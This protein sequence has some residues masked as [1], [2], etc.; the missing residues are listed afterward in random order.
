MNNLFLN[1]TKLTSVIFG[2]INTL[3]LRNMGNMFYGCSS[4]KDL[5]L[6]NFDT[7]KV[8]NMRY[9]FYKCISLISLN[10]SM[11]KASSLNDSSYMFAR[12]NNLISLDL[13]NFNTSQTTLMNYMFYNCQLLQYLNISNFNTINVTGMDYMFKYCFSLKYLDLS[14]FY[15]PNLKSN[16]EMFYG[17]YSLSSLDISNFNTTLINDLSNLFYNCSSLLYLNLSSFNTIN[18]KKMEYMFYNF[19]SL[20]SLNLNNFNTEKVE[21]MLGMFYNC[22]KLT[23][24]DLSSFNTKS[25]KSMHYMFDNCKKLKKLNLSHFYTPELKYM[26]YM[27]YMCNSLTSLD[28]TNLNTT[29]T[30]N[31]KYAFSHCKKL[32]QLNVSNFDTS[33]VVNMSFTFRYLS[34]LKSLDLSNFDTSSVKDMQHMFSYCKSLIYLNLSNFKTISV[35]NIRQM[36][37]DCQN[38]QYIDFYLYNESLIVNLNK[39]LDY[40]PENIIV[41]LNENNNID[42]FKSSILKKNYSL[43]YCGDDW[44]DKQIQILE[45]YTYILSNSEEELDEDED[46]GNINGNI[47]EENKDKDNCGQCL[48]EDDNDFDI[49]INTNT[50]SIN[51]SI[52]EMNNTYIDENSDNTNNIDYSITEALFSEMNDDTNKMKSWLLKATNY[53]NTYNNYSDQSMSEKINLSGISLLSQ[54]NDEKFYN[55]NNYTSQE[56]NQMIYQNITN[57]ILNNFDPL[58]DDEIIIE[59]KDNVHY[60]L[61]TL[62][63]AKNNTHEQISRIDIGECEDKLRQTNNINNNTALLILLLEKKSNISSERNLQFEIYESLNKTKLDLTVCKDI[64]IEIYVPLILNDKLINLYNELKELGYDLFNINDKFYQDICTPYTTENNTDA[65]LSDRINYYYNNDQTQCQAGCDFSDYVFEIQKLKCE[66]NITKTQIN[67]EIKIGDDGLKSLYKSFYDVLK[68]S[69]YKVLKCYKLAFSWNNFYK[70]IGTILVLVYFVIYL[71]FLLIYVFKEKDELRIDLVKIMYNSNKKEINNNIP[72]IIHQNPDAIISS[73]PLNDTQNKKIKKSQRNS[74]SEKRKTNNTVLYPPKKG[75]SLRK[76]KIKSY[77]KESVSLNQL[78]KTINDIKEK[79]DI[80]KTPL[81]LNNSEKNEI[82]DNFEL[83]DMEYD[84]ALKSDKRNFIQIYW[85]ILRREHLIIFTFFIRNDHNL[86]NI[87]YVRFIFLLCT[88]MALN[89]FFFSDETMHKMFLDYGKYNFIQ[90]IPQIVYSTIVTQ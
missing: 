39:I 13:Y 38:L 71:T 49:D 26:H 36:F 70:N 30:V 89:V 80:T 4:L 23:S 55:N 42:L 59:G 52:N 56:I 79:K 37:Y 66:C 64:P 35:T 82:F 3:K 17:A 69:N 90:Q 40:T 57:N 58:K 73:S 16:N 10:I 78:L 8:T 51:N 29:K 27:F 63:K 54:I 18:T 5:N 22:L 15:T 47:D 48:I 43:I 24:I 87:K 85:S 9:M 1:C 34:S 74:K 88:D 76:N 83:N 81:E 11:F 32:T 53:E 45:N 86:V 7:S 65:L 20:S 72:I 31:M 61:M 25:V 67:D 33:N 14:H 50:S 84:K 21:S 62:E 2:N 68:Y 44:K 75:K 19:S 46:D 28:I 41:C 6:T 60:V 12:D 77:K